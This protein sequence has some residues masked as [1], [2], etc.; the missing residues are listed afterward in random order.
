MCSVFNNFIHFITWEQRTG[1]ISCTRQ[2]IRT[3]SHGWWINCIR[4]ELKFTVGS[5]LCVYCRIGSRPARVIGT[6]IFIREEISRRARAR[7]STCADFINDNMRSPLTDQ[8]MCAASFFKIVSIHYDE[9]RLSQAVGKNK[10]KIN[11]WQTRL[12]IAHTNDFIDSNG[13]IESELREQT[14]KKKI[15]N[16]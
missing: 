1:A 6:A 3:R 10:N 8:C 14:K 7:A 12:D 13:C 2:H 11:R 4:G 15:K 16:T 9:M 5:S